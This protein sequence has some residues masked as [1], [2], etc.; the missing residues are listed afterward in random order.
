MSKT[1]SFQNHAKYYP[2][3]HFVIMPLVLVFFGWTIARVNFGTS[4]LTSGSIY[5]LLL[6][7]V[8]LLISYLPRIYALKNQ[9]RI[10]R[11]E[12]RQYYFHLTGNTF[13]E[14]E[15]QL[16]TAQIVALRFAAE[17]EFLALIE[18]TINE[19]TAP[20]DIKK[21]IVNWKADHHRV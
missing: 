11:L 5:F 18:K 14:K 1:Q 6:G 10:I 4:Q 19:K 3:H 12:M 7:L 15:S 21:N 9:N 17:E 16:T 2:F 20:K 13:Y 8:V